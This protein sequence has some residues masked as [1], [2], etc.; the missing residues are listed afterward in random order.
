LRRA[1]HAALDAVLS[2]PSPTPAISE[3]LEKRQLLSASPAHRPLAKLDSTLTYAYQDYVRSGGTTPGTIQVEANANVG[4]RVLLR[5]AL[6][7][8]K[9]IDISGTGRAMDALIP[10]SE[11]GKLANLKSLRFADA[12]TGIANT[13][14]VTS[15]GDIADIAAAARAGVQ[16]QRRGCHRRDPL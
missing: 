11:L 12:P 14:S 4:D 15:Q 16:R 1:G 10:I 8:L 2:C 7:H 3:R 5:S 13:G 9:A 6:K